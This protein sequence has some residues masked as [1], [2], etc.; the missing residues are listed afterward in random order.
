MGVEHGCP[1]DAKAVRIIVIWAELEILQW[2]HSN[3]YLSKHSDDAFSEIILRTAVKKQKLETLRWCVKVGM[4]FNRQGLCAR[5]ARKANVEMLQ[6][7]FEQCAPRDSM[8]LK[9]A[10]TTKRVHIFDWLWSN[11]PFWKVWYD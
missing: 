7:L 1:F 2:A 3:G 8:L 9:I 5:A 10:G 11:S 4:S 6:F